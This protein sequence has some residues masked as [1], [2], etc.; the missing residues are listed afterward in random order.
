[1]GNFRF[2]QRQS[3]V[4]PLVLAEH[5]GRDSNASRLND[6]VVVRR[7]MAGV[8]LP[9]MRGHNPCAGAQAPP[10]PIGGFIASSFEKRSRHEPV[11]EPDG[12]LHRASPLGTPHEGVLFVP[13]IEQV[14]KLGKKIIR[15]RNEV[16]LR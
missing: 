11:Y 14:G 13:I 12:L 7:G 9:H 15:A 1:M 4:E 3:F 2:K 8:V 10:Q 5:R 16:G 6:C